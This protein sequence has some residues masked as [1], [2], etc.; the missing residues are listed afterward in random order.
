MTPEEPASARRVRQKLGTSADGPPE[1][2]TYQTRKPSYQSWEIHHI[3]QA[4]GKVSYYEHRDRK[5]QGEWQYGLPDGLDKQ[6]L[7]SGPK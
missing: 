4:G 5:A 3:S 6:D 1:I 2:T 7:E